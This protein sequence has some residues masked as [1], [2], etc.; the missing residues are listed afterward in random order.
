[1]TQ[2]G[3]EMKFVFPFALFL[4]LSGCAITSVERNP[5][6]TYDISANSGNFVS[7]WL[8]LDVPVTRMDA[9]VKVARKICKK[10]KSPYSIEDIS[11]VGKSVT[12]ASIHCV[13]RKEEERKRLVAAKLKKDSEESEAR[14]EKDR[15]ETMKKL[16]E[17]NSKKIAPIVAKCVKSEIKEV[18]HEAYQEIMAI[19]EDSFI[20]QLTIVSL[21]SCSLEPLD[22]QSCELS[23]TNATR[24]DDQSSIYV[25][26]LNLC[27]LQEGVACGKFYSIEK[28]RLHQTQDTAKKLSDLLK[29]T[30]SLLVSECDSHQKTSCDYIEQFS[31]N[32]DRRESECKSLTLYSSKRRHLNEQEYS[33]KEIEDKRHKDL[34]QSQTDIAEA[35]LEIANSQDEMIRIEREKAEIDKERNRILNR[36]VKATEKQAVATEEIAETTEATEERRRLRNILNSFSKQNKNEI[37]CETDNYGGLSSTTTCRGH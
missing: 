16:Y 33:K 15:L 13:D 3:I 36:Q 28:K 12:T 10:R 35:Q 7:K 4:I 9:I 31:T 18:C 17:S 5:D 1:M 32:C 26:L 20:S 2:I 8:D 25:S 37:K 21:K 34:I 24:I 27:I 22:V 11:E 6:D 29:T 30:A 19:D 14:M 23:L